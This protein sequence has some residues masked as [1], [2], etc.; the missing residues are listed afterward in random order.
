MK[1]L[2]VSDYINLSQSSVSNYFGNFLPVFTNIVAAV[3][4][5]AIGITVGWVLKW[6]VSELSR[7]VGLER[8]LAGF[9]FYGRIVKSHS[10]N[11]L[12]TFVG[13][14]VRWSAII[15]FL[16]PAVASL[17]VSG[18]DAAFTQ[19]F[20]YVSSVI[21]ASVY[22]LFG[23]VIAWFIHRVVLAVGVVVGT[24]PA[25]LVANVVYLAIVVFAVVQALL[26]LGITLDMIRLATIAVL[27]AGALAFGLAGK[28]AATDLVKKFMD[29]AK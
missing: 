22:L 3:V 25:H 1:K 15:V 16:I 10:E 28:D 27:A 9:P 21:A 8:V 20:G 17:T 19:L 14:A 5:V 13:E 24:N 26:Q 18:A 4:T 2:T 11:D 6:V 23:F 29:R 12:T 7:S